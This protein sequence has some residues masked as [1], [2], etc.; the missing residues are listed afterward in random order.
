V[1]IGSISTTLKC[2]VCGRTEP[3]P[4]SGDW[5]FRANDFLIDAY[6]EHGVEAV[7]YALWRV[8]ERARNSFYFAPS[9]K[10]WEDYPERP[11]A[12]TREIDAL[13]VVDGRLY[14]CEAKNSAALSRDEIESLVSA[15][16]RIRPDVVLVVCMEQDATGLNRA[17]EMLRERLPQKIETELLAFRAS[18]LEDDP[19]LPH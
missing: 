10:L 16:T 7:I 3:A 8:S 5:H 14:L 12:V 4:V 18:D 17:M 9:I 19:I 1:T 11:E 6:R 2:D 13:M 15:A